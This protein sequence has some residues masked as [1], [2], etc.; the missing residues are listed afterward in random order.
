MTDE[1]QNEATEPE[2]TPKF[3]TGFIVLKGEGGAWHV[4]T[5]LTA[6]IEIERE[7]GVSE[8]R[9]ATTEITYSIGQQQLA[10]LIL[11]ALSPQPSDVNLEAQ[12]EGTIKE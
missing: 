9:A 5:D 4:L 10:A 1:T 6:D 7:V 11:S 2:K 12:T 3:E 8:V